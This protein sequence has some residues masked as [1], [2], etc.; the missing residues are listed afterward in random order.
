MTQLLFTGARVFDGRDVLDGARSVLVEDDRI[1][2]VSDRPIRAPDARVLDVAGRTLMPGLIDAHMHATA[3]D[4]N[5]ARVDGA[6]AA[7]RTA[8]AARML[9]HLLDCGFT[10]ARDVGG[11]DLSLAR[12]IGDGLIRAPRYFYAGKA[13]SM[14]GGHGDLRPPEHSAP[15]GAP[16]ACGPSNAFCHI[17]D[18][19]DACLRAARE[20]LRKGAHCIKIM[21]SGGVASPSD[22]IWMNQYRDDEIRAIVGEA[23]ARRSYVAAH[24]HPAAAVR[25][26]VELGVRTIEHGTLIDDET[27]RFVAGSD[28]YVVP[29]MVV[30]FALVELGPTLGF[31]PRSQAK[32]AEVYQSALTGLDRMRR[33]GVKVGL[34]TDLLGSTHVQ[35]TRELTIRREVFTPLEILR[36]ATSVNAELMQLAGQLGCVAPGA[37]ADLLVVDGDPDADLGLL[38]DDGRGLRAILRGGELVKNEL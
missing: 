35:Q 23:A 18:G 4:V 6:G 11:G 5:I 8:Y 34:G 28:A 38:T 3:C 10:S 9:G 1:R 2:E 15:D 7:Y 22:P 24:C 37:H 31:P 20:E 25:R 19:V 21:G 26:C 13:L 17:A 33:A 30:I 29:T 32:V 12:A 16:C 36:Q 27:A 14:T